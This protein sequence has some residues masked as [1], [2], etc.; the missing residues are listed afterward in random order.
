[1]LMIMMIIMGMTMMMTTTMTMMMTTM[2]GRYDSEW[3]RRVDPE[4]DLVIAPNTTNQA[5][6]HRSVGSKEY[7][8]ALPRGDPSVQQFLKASRLRSQVRHIILASS[9]IG[10]HGLTKC[11]IV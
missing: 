7:L 3:V 5:W 8:P 4:G 2:I 11:C 1:M 9:A 6:W 10:I